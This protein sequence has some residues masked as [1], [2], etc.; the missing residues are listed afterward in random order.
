VFRQLGVPGLI[1]M[2]TFV[3]ILAFGLAY[4]WRRGA[5]AWD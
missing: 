1:E 3:V 5:L 4:V 2:M